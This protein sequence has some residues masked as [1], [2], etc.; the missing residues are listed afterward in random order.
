M[1]VTIERLRQRLVEKGLEGALNRAKYQRKSHQIKVDG[2]VQAHLIALSW[3]EGAFGPDDCW[4]IKW[5]NWNM[6]RAYLMKRYVK[7]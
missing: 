1:S 3:R 2:E 6:W 4:L 5:L 7:F